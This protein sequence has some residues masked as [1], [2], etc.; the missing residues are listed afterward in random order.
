MTKEEIFVF[1]DELVAR[2]EGPAVQVYELAFGANLRGAILFVSIGLFLV[3]LGGAAL[4]FSVWNE[5]QRRAGITEELRARGYGNGFRE[6]TIAANII[7]GFAIGI[8][9]IMTMF[10]TYDLLTVGW[11]TLQQIVPG[12]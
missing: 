6:S 3:L 2:L 8:G 12:L 9:L 4:L 11:R 7:G 1:L 5:R 10:A